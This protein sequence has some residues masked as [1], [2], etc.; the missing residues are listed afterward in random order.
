MTQTETTPSFQPDPDGEINLLDRA[1][2]P[3]VPGP[4]LRIWERVS[5]RVIPR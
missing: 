4:L 5:S 3:S 2:V 1:L